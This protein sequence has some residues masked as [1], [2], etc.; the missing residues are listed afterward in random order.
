MTESL[1]RRVVPDPA[2]IESFHRD[3]YILYEDVMREDTREGL[4]DEIYGMPDVAAYVDAPVPDPPQSFFRR[5]WDDRGPIG[6]RLIDDPFVLELLRQTVE[7]DVHFCHSALNLAP[8]GI[9]AVR[10]HQDHHHWNHDNPI[11]LAERN[12]YYIQ[13]L[14]YPNGFTVGDRNVKVIPGSHRVAPTQQATPE[15]M[16]AGEY[17][18]EAGRPLQEVRLQV[19]P[20]SMVYIDARMFH[21]VEAKPQDS[22]QAHRIFCIDIFKQAGP[23]HRHTQPIP[24]Q[25]LASANDTRRQLFDREP[26]V[27]GCWTDATA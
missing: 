11:N 6:H 18:D 14:Y 15:R 24:P 8:R 5:P 23:P 17:D 20:G 9:D 22:G 1:F 13:I 16:L 26:Y 4:I 25:W 21:A 27:D 19:A 2:D 12:G 3:G 7:D 10:Y